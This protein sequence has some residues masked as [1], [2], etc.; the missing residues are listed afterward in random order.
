MT[1]HR[2][3]EEKLASSE[4]FRT[5]R[6]ELSAVEAMRTHGW[7]ASH[8]PY[9]KD[10][11]TGKLRELDAVGRRL[12]EKNRKPTKTLARVNLFV[13]VKSASDFHVLCAGAASDQQSF[14]SN[15]YWLGY[16]EETQRRVRQAVEE[17]GLSKTQSRD[18]LHQVEQLCFP[19][20]TMRTSAL[21]INPLPAAHC[22]SAF[23]ETNGDKEKELDNSVMWRAVSALRSAVASAREDM[24]EGF[25]GD[26][27]VDLEISRR[28][29]EAPSTNLFTLEHRAS[30]IDLYIP[31]VL[32]E[33]RLWSAEGE[34]P[35]EIPWFRLLEND[36]IGS[37]QRWTDVVNQKH[38]EEYL[39]ALT[40]HI[41]ECYKKVRAKAWVHS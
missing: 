39:S 31:I 37:S 18:F 21:R 23:R 8:S 29:N 11:V 26:L 34:S 40:K 10:V 15:E 27:K 16:C 19:R 2:P 17:F 14:V 7:A 5:L 41:T 24:I 33:S 35:E 12:W 6:S 1:E 28:H 25:V 13:E 9:Y 3:I 4:A 30:T 32:I 38:F 20:H 36:F 22:Y